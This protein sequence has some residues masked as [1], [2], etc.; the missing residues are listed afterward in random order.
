MGRPLTPKNAREEPLE[1]I[2]AFIFEEISFIG[3]K[4]REKGGEGEGEGENMIA[5]IDKIL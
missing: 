1:V 4:K 3:K 2:M 5:I